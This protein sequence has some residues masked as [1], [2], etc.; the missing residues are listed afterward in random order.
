MLRW[1]LQGGYSLGCGYDGGESRWQAGRPLPLDPI[2]PSLVGRV[3]LTGLYKL[4]QKRGWSSYAQHL[5]VAA[6]RDP[7]DP[8]TG[9]E[10]KVQLVI[11]RQQTGDRAQ[12]TSAEGDSHGISLPKQKRTRA[13]YRPGSRLKG[14]YVKRGYAE[15]LTYLRS[16]GILQDYT[17]PTETPSSPDHLDSAGRGAVYLSSYFAVEKERGKSSRAIFH[18]KRLSS[19]CTETGL[20]PVGL[21]LPTQ[22][23]II[24]WMARA[25]GNKGRLWCVTG[26]WRHWF[27]QLRPWPGLTLLFGLRLRERKAQRVFLWQTLPMG[28]L[29]SPLIAQ[30]CSWIVLNYHEIGERPFFMNATEGMEGSGLPCRLRTHRELEFAT[31]FYDNFIFVTDDETRAHQCASRILRNTDQLRVVV[32]PR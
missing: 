20:S 29:Y 7:R 8:N 25:L 12:Q 4:C 15:H 14:P 1:M 11:K 17:A 24:E 13:E 21:N 26:D 10:S 16:V 27:H 22:T 2:E 19:D 30:C 6:G 31:V 32:K 9:L 23:Q 3:C 28:W 5:R 18:G